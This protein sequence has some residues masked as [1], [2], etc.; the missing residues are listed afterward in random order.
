KGRLGPTPPVLTGGF[1]FRRWH[2][3]FGITGQ[4]QAFATFPLSSPQSWP[5]CGNGHGRLFDQRPLYSQK[6]TW[7]GTIAMSALCQ[8]GHRPFHSIIRSAVA[9]NAGG[10]SRPSNFAV[11][12]LIRSRNFV[13]CSIG[14]SSG[15]VPCKILST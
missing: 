11:V 9:S 5:R 3:N 12:R 14:S 15:R 7:F 13:G 2:G 8:K 6:R 10:M 1:Y 4:N